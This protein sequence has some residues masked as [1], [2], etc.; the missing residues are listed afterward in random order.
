MIVTADVVDVAVRCWLGNFMATEWIIGTV[1]N[2][3]V[4]FAAA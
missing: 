3:F 2:R 1:D 4:A